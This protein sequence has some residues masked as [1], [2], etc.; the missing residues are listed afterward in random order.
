MFEFQTLNL[1]IGLVEFHYA[2]RLY[3][4][5]W[6]GFRFQWCITYEKDLYVICPLLI[7]LICGV[8]C[9]NNSF[10]STSEIS[11]FSVICISSMVIIFGTIFD[12]IELY[13]CLRI[14]LRL[15]FVI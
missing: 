14:L 4:N 13:S 11:N 5:S 8:Y 6:K 1:D 9:S 12:L 10:L 3:S 2:W 15:Y 7:K